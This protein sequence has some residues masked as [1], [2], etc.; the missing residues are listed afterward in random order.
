MINI[1][2]GNIFDLDKK[3]ILIHCISLD[4]MMEAGIAYQ[5]NRRFPKMKPFIIN[6]VTRQKL[7]KPSVVYYN[8]DGFHIFNL[9]TKD[10]YYNKPTYSNI[11]YCLELVRDY[12][13]NKNIK[14]I[15]MPKIGCG[16]DKR[17]W[18]K[19]YSIIVKVFENTDINIL[20]KTN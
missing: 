8:T 4:C 19:M 15:A 10:S 16:L 20:I 6:I 13:I 3:Y 18:D 17:N 12:C 7:K 5:F 1:E 14:Y 2:Y 11:K 9:I